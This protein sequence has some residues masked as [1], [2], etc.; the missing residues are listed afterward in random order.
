MKRKTKT[1]EKPQSPEYEKV[2]DLCNR[3]NGES[4]AAV[5]RDYI[6]GDLHR[7]FIV[8]DAFCNRCREE[9]AAMR[10]GRVSSRLRICCCRDTFV[11]LL[12]ESAETSYRGLY[13]FGDTEEESEEMS[14]AGIHRKWLKGMSSQELEQYLVDNEY[15]SRCLLGEINQQDVARQ[16]RYLAAVRD[17]CKTA[18]VA[19]KKIKSDSCLLWLEVLRL[20]TPC[21]DETEDLPRVGT[22]LAPEEMEKAYTVAEQAQAKL[23]VDMEFLRL[24]VS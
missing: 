15:C 7:C 24:K 20:L 10:K 19:A 13:P 16:E 8:A 17:Y 14:R 4:A 6:N 5:R 21:A 11:K 9:I 1:T 22:G 3:L 12:S 23:W 18:A 2:G